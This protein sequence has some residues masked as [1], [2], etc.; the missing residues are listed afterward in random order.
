MPLCVMEVQP[1]FLCTPTKMTVIFLTDEPYPVEVKPP[2]PSNRLVENARK[3]TTNND[4]SNDIEKQ[5][6]ESISEHYDGP[7]LYQ[8]IN[9]DLKVSLITDLSK[10]KNDRMLQRRFRHVFQD[11]CESKWTTIM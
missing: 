2:L 8:V 6:S 4:S 3:N 9:N 11:I 10:A 7:K 1:K 5:L